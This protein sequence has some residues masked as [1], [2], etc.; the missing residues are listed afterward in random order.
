MTKDAQEDVQVEDDVVDETEVAEM[1][2]DAPKSEPSTKSTPAVLERMAHEPDHPELAP[3]GV[4]RGQPASEHR[5]QP[6]PT[7]EIPFKKIVIGVTDGGLMRILHN[8]IPVLAL[9]E[10]LRRLSDQ[11]DSTIQQQAEAF[12]RSQDKRT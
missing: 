9:R 1:M 6:G 7:L 2:K 11:V 3:D 12:E 4:K 8:D 5:A 10:L